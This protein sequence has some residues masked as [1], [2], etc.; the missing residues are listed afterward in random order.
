MLHTWRSRI[1]GRHSDLPSVI[2]SHA[3]PALIHLIPRVTLISRGKWA[4]VSH[5]Q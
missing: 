3:R 1:A 2:L 4:N 5:T